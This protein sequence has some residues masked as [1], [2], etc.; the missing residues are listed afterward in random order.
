MPA[1]GLKKH[2]SQGEHA[3]RHFSISST[4]ARTKQVLK[5]PQGISIFLTQHVSRQTDSGVSSILEASYNS[6]TKNLVDS[7]ITHPQSYTAALGTFL[8]STH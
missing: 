5:S 4:S 7:L 1:N 3:T 8:S 2:L 6:N